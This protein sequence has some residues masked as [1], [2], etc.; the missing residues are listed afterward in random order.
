MGEEITFY[1]FK[2]AINHINPNCGRECA[3]VDHGAEWAVL[4]S[5]FG[6]VGD[7]NFCRN[8]NNADLPWCFTDNNMYQYC[9]ECVNIIV[10]VCDGY[11]N[12]LSLV[13]EYSIYIYIYIYFPPPSIINLFIEERRATKLLI[14]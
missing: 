10:N 11:Y 1:P 3:G 13:I 6:E 12:I 4:S 2:L 5:E 7:H 14:Y 9:C 8:P